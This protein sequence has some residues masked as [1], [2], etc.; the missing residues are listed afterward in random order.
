[1]NSPLPG[2]R[3]APDATGAQADARTPPSVRERPY[4]PWFAS[5]TAGGR[6][7]KASRPER[8]AGRPLRGGD[9][10][11]FLSAHVPGPRGR[12]PYRSRALAR[13]LAAGV[14]GAGV[15]V[16]AAV[17]AQ[18]AGY[19]YWSFWERADGAWSYANQGPAVLRPVDGDVL[20][21]RFSVSENSG[22]AAKPR[23][24]AGFQDICGGTQAADGTKRIALSVDFGT[25]EDAPG[26]ER[27]PK[28]RTACARVAEDATA[29]DALAATMKPLR[30]N[31]S[32]LL[33]A[34]DGYP[35]RGCGEQ[36]SAD[37]S[38]DAGAGTEAAPE[39]ESDASEH[40]GDGG[41]A[42]GVGV[43]VGVVV[44]LAAGAFRQTRR[45]RS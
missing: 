18:A 41:T 1:M 11:V 17:P 19:R 15:L 3:P 5:A 33:C 23:G 16:S 12:W 44:A 13:A 31:S 14:L 6:P 10:G 20:G 21:F 38:P 30:Y 40:S 43:G 9:R 22:D 7:V 29:A 42:V 37:G 8:T 25:A 36:V 32:A 4:Q 34:I 26:G 39:P 45:R 2:L 24:A 35:E 27:P 28:A